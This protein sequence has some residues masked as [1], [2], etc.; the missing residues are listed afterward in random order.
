MLHFLSMF[1]LFIEVILR[2]RSCSCLCPLDTPVRLFRYVS[3]EPGGFVGLL[4]GGM[5]EVIARVRPAPWRTS[6]TT[7]CVFIASSVWR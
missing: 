2:V 4:E 3:N 5:F 7:T 6:E 1:A